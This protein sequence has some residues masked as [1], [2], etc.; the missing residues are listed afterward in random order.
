MGAID[1]LRASARRML[2][3]RVLPA[4]TARGYGAYAPG[5]GFQPPPWFPMNWWQMGFRRQPPGGNAAVEACVSAIS[6]TIASMP[7]QL[8]RR[9]PNGGLEEITSGPVVEVLRNPNPY[10]TRADFVLNL[11]RT[12]LLRGNGVAVAERRRNSIVALHGLPSDTATPYIAEDGS[13]FY[14]LAS[15]TPL[16]PDPPLETFFPATDVLHVR[17]QTPHHPLIGETP[18]IA[19]ALAVEA[20]NAIGGHMAGFFQNMTRPS[21]YLAVPKTLK[22]EVADKLR[23]E[24]EKAYSADN[25]GRIAV[26][27]DGLEWKP[28]SISSVDSQLIESYR[29]TVEDVARVFRVPLAVIGHMGGATFGNTETL[30]RHWLSTGLGYMLEH[31]ELALDKLFALPPDQQIAFDV[32]SLLRSDFPAR[33]DALTKGILGG[34]FSPNEARQREGLKAVAFGDEPRV[35]AQVVPLSFAGRPVPSNPSAPS[36]PSAS[37]GAEAELVTAHAYLKHLRSK[38]HAA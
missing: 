15:S 25:T 16:M 12:E 10:Q 27:T 2:N 29:L 32:E 34:L 28:M 18:L 38:R 13:V 20:G 3:E 30:I 5:S 6:Q 35:Q 1:R 19:A 7:L 22:A 24:W 8:W 36:T 11:V 33:I 4:I 23:Q 14:S 31:L 21:G 17:M 26:L 37:K 9:L